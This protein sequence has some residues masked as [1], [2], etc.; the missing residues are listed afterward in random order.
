M[1]EMNPGRRSGDRGAG[2]EVH[3]ALGVSGGIGAYKAAGIVRA[4]RTLDSAVTVLMTANA[5]NFI[6]PLTLKTLSGN[7]VLL[8]QFDGVNQEWDVEHVSLAKQ[9]SCLLVAPATANIIGKFANGIA[10]DFLTTFYTAYD[11][12]VFVAP[13]MNTVMYE[14]P[15]VQHNL[16]V[17]RRRG[18]RIIEP[19]SGYLACGDTSQGRLADPDAIVRQVLD[20]VG[21]GERDLLAGIR[22]LVTAGPTREAIDPVRY[23]SNHSSGKMGYALARQASRLGATVTLISG[24]TALRAPA[25]CRLVQ[26][27]TCAEMHREVQRVFPDND[28]LLM[29]AAPADYRP[30]RVKEEKIH[31]SEASL[32]LD[33]Q[34]TDDIIAEAGS[35]K[36]GQILVG[37]AAETVADIEAPAMEKLRR[38]GLDLIVANRVGQPGTGFDVDENEGLVLGS[39][40]SRTTLARMTKD[41][42]ALEI[43]RCAGAVIDKRREKNVQ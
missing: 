7:R 23:L 22:V 4:L 17:L 33:L 15:A 12:P 37:F 24:P 35:R 2:P 41:R 38:K 13:A 14:H 43:L 27:V 9:A 28:L 16:E 36:A 25:G 8:D 29:A 10:D 3:V 21:G 11:G 40:G 18:V 5:T 39:D 19:E 6:T 42:M 31:K 1:I 32:R 20:V 34:R 26:V 30:A